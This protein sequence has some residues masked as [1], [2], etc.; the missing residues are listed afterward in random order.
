MRGWVKAEKCLLG[1][2]LRH[3]KTRGPTR[4]RKEGINPGP[5]P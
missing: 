5:H 3:D 1:C 2:R 4:S